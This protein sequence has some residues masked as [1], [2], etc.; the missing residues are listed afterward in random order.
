MDD[1]KVRNMEEFAAVCGISRPTLSKYFQ[2]PGSVRASTRERIEAALERH[3][4]RPNLYAVNQNR[5]HSKA[6]GIVV[7]YLA[8]PFFAE[9]ARNIETLVIDAGFR[10]ILLSA[11]GDPAHEAD[12]LDGLRD[13][14][15]AGVLLAPLGRAS[16]R[17]AV[18]AFCAAVPTVLFD[19]NLV[20]QAEA[21]I[22]SDN[23]Q[24]IALI[25]DHLCDTGEPPAFFE[26][27]S[28]VNPNAFKRREAYAAAMARRGHAPMTLQVE[29]RGWDFEAIGRAGA[30]KAIE[31]RA[32]PSDTILCSND[33]LAVGFLSAAYEKG[34]RVGVGAGC[35]LRVAGHD[36]HPYA[37]FASPRLTTVSQDYAAISRA[38]AAAL[39]NLI[40]TGRRAGRRETTLFAGRLVRRES[41]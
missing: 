1:A 32:L 20:G 34:L 15:P 5:R 21:F 17:R 37:R 19:S 29:G 26:M 8:D 24:S 7:P 35:A 18:E 3:D 9:L 31:A 2:D 33:R 6:I 30:L 22:G 25:V 23:D 40:D 41:A 4:F 16:D 11:H 27:A 38:S 12:I 39:L 13:L 28:P 36:D 14:K 10:P